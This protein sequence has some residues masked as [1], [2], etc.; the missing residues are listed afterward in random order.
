MT[1]GLLRR[2]R[3]GARILRH[4]R[5][6]HP[7]GMGEVAVEALVLEVAN[8]LGMRPGRDDQQ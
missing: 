4:G 5:R 7:V 8:R 2:R 1:R 3:G 6:R